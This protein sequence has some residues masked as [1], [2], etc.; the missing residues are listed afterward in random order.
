MRNTLQKK[1][2]EV[3]DKGRLKRRESILIIHKIPPYYTKI[4]NLSQF[5]I[6]NPTIYAN[7]HTLT[8]Y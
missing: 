4:H 2:K 1:I 5:K 3:D 6:K 7:L 8:I